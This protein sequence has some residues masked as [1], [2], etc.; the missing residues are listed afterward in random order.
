M[1]DIAPVF[2]TQTNHPCLPLNNKGRAAPAIIK[3]NIIRK[4]STTSN[5]SGVEKSKK[6]NSSMRNM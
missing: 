6:T 5:G 1:A 3:K 2:H 4:Y